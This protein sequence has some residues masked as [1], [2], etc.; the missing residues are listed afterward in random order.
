MAMRHRSRRSS[1]K[2]C[3]TTI[4]KMQGSELKPYNAF[5]VCH[6][7]TGYHGKTRDIGLREYEK[8]HLPKDIYERLKEHH[9][10]HHKKHG[11]HEYGY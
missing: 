9:S 1:F 10:V 6:H 5:A 8:V 7:S 4:T 2:H 11:A 3:I